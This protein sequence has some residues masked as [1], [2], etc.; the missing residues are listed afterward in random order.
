MEPYF[1]DERCRIFNGDAREVI[2]SLG[3]FD[4]LLTTAPLFP[5]GLTS[6]NKTR[7]IAG[8]S[9]APQSCK[10]RPENVAPVGE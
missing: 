6:E 4:L 2:P 3:R 9:L 8:R 7:M 5:P 1:E 10:R